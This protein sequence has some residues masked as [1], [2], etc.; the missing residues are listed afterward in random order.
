MISICD[1]VNEDLITD[2]LTDNKHTALRELMSLI[3]QHD[4]SIDRRTFEKAIFDRESLLS[5]GIGLG[6]AVPHARLKNLNT[7]HVA[8]G[9]SHAGIEYDAIDGRSVNLIFMISAPDN[10]TEEP[11]GKNI[12]LHLL[13]RISE[14]ARNESIRKKI[15][16]APTNKEIASILRDF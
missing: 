10:D 14:I 9:R 2:L 15:L 16:S 13:S 6:I 1:Y 4:T 3:Y 7:F 8:L 12:Y 11:G 5:T